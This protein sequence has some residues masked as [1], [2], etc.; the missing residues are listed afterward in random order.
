MCERILVRETALLSPLQCF[1]DF[2]GEL[3]V[4]VEFIALTHDLCDKFL[5]DFLIAFIQ[6]SSEFQ[7]GGSCALVAGIWH[8]PFANVDIINV[9]DGA[10][11][12][13]LNVLWGDYHDLAGAVY[14]QVGFSGLNGCT[15]FTDTD[16]VI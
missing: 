13:V 16:T 15:C 11:E 12:A 14:I 1:A 7:I 9:E 5:Y 3:Y 10:F 6:G 2:I 8:G 4:A